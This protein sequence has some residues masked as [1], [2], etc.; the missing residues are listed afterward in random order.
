MDQST[1]KSRTGYMIT[2]AG[3]LVTW[4]S[5]MQTGVVLSTTEAEL[6][7]MSA[8]SRIAIPMMRLIEEITDQ[9]I[10]NMDSCTKVHF[11]VFKVNMG[12]LTIATIP[13][14]R[15]RKTYINGKYWHCREQLEHGKIS[16]HAVSTKNQ[17][18]DLLTK[19]SAENKFINLRDKFMGTEIVD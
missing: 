5:K 10:A 4:A 6:I 15:P 18:A 11:K 19:P 2:Y 16:N 3:C 9:E 14:I 12:A 17:I 1:A 13:K 8:G 7:V